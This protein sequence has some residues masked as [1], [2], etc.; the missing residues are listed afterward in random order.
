MEEDLINAF[1]CFALI[2]QKNEDCAMMTMI[3]IVKLTDVFGGNVAEFMNRIKFKDQSPP[4]HSIGKR[5][6]S[7][8]FF[9]THNVTKLI[10]QCK[11][12][13]L[14]G[15]FVLLHY[16]LLME[17]VVRKHATQKKIAQGGKNA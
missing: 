3:A 8:E 7:T 14:L 6:F 9:E 1:K 13:F 5:Q 16:N 15:Q 4:S 10:D 11:N 2:L 17:Y 12:K